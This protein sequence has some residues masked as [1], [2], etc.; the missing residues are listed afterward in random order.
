[1]VE[2][3]QHDRLEEHGLR[4][5]PFHDEDRRAGKVQVSFGVSPDVPPETVGC[6]ITQRGLVHDA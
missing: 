6:E 4:E 1:V 5:S 2:D 3:G